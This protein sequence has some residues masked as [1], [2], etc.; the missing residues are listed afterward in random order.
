MN[1]RTSYR[2]TLIQ[3]VHAFLYPHTLNWYRFI[4]LA[5]LLTRAATSV[6]DVSTEL[7]PCWPGSF[8]LNSQI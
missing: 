8:G 4:T 6:Q 5:T 3:F 2:F 7:L 1:I